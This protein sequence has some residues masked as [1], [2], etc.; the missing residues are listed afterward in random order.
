[1]Q[2]TPR[3]KDKLLIAMAAEVAR[4]RLARGVR[5]NRDGVPLYADALRLTGD[6]TAILAGTA[7]GGGAGAAAT[8][9]YAAPDAEAFRD[10]V[11]A[12]L[13]ETGGASLA[14]PGLLVVRL[15]AGDSF[16]LRVSLIP[17]LT[18]LNGS[19]LPRSWML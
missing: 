15:L 9:L 14:R 13:P 10:P 5:L 19:A 6:A 8:V 3:D 17:I 18:L 12:L 4:K 11:R 16:D 2:L 7:T 1:M